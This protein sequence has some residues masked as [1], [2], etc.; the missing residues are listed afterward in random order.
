[1]ELEWAVRDLDHHKS[2]SEVDSK[3][4]E[5]E[6]ERERE[7]RHIYTQKKLREKGHHI[8]SLCY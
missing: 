7:K 8:K 2:R 3:R 4:I 1:V 5:H 6:R